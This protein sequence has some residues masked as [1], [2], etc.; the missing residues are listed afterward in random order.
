M[1]HYYGM[2]TEHLL[3][4]GGIY[5]DATGKTISTVGRLAANHGAFFSRLEA[6][7]DITSRR[8][9]RIL[10]WFSDRWPLDLD[11]PADIPRPEPTTDSPAAK[12]ATEALDR[13]C[14][15]PVTAVTAARRT[16]TDAAFA[17]DWNAAEAAEQVML[18]AATTL[19]DGRIASVTA[20]CLALG[21]N[22]DRYEYVLKHYRRDRANG[23]RPRAK[24]DNAKVLRALEIAGDERFS[25]PQLER[26]S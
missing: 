10:Q 1:Y 8:A 18:T 21:V 16:M 9:A 13:T 20:L 12:A 11:W 26:A 15:D 7:H 22:R 5:A 17:D 25:R 4:L 6:G 24:T 3:R 2:S 23:K 14:D 19:R